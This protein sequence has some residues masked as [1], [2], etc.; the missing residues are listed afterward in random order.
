MTCESVDSKME[1]LVLPGE[2]ECGTPKDQ[3]LLHAR[4]VA[5]NKGVKYGN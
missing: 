2:K 1:R 4:T 5:K 3:S